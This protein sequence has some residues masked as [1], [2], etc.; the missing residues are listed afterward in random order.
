M[1]FWDASALVPVCLEEEKSPVVLDLVRNDESPGSATS[2]PLTRCSQEKH[3][4][5]R[6]ARRC[7]AVPAAS[8]R[9]V[10]GNSTSLVFTRTQPARVRRRSGRKSQLKNNSV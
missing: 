10:A 1:K 8:M 3:A 2:L 6:V 4:V 9:S 5:E 7:Y